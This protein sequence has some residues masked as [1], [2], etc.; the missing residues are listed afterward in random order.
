MRA[1]DRLADIGHAHSWPSDP[2]SWRQLANCELCGLTMLKLIINSSDWVV[3][4]VEHVAFLDECTVRR[5]VS[6]DYEAPPNA[7]IL[8][9]PGGQEVRVLPLAIMRRKSLVNFDLRDDDGR[10]VP[11]LGL[12][13][14]QAL[15]FGIVRAWAAATLRDLDPPGTISPGTYEFLDD[16]VAG[17]QIELWEAFNRMWAAEPGGQLR[18]AD[19]DP[20]A[21]S[22]VL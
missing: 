5:R 14:N 9:R 7:V 6:I 3:R 11:L 15:T 12:R 10:A 18:R 22:P 4:R 19:E 21:A 8:R 2:L 20:R 1:Y 17:D 16:V 13:Q